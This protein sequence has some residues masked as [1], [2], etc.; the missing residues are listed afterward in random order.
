MQRERKQDVAGWLWA[1]AG[2]TVLAIY[3]LFLAANA[4]AV[5]RFGRSARRR[6][7]DRE[8]RFDRQAYRPAVR[9]TAAT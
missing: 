3:V 5:G 8:E 9:E 6:P 4:W 2:L 1:A 7:E